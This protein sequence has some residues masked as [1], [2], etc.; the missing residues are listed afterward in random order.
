M[1]RGPSGSG[2]SAETFSQVLQ[3]QCRPAGGE[4]TAGVETQRV[5]PRD[6]PVRSQEGWGQAGRAEKASLKPTNLSQ[7]NKSLRP[8]WEELQSLSPPGHR[9]R[10]IEAGGTDTLCPSWGGR[11][12]QRSPTTGKGRAMRKPHPEVQG[13]GD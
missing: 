10:L 2:D 9:W 3:V 12:R 6:L 13:H 11:G 5:L 4:K 8:P 1:G 7:Q